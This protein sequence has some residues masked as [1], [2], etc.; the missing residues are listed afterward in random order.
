MVGVAPPTFGRNPIPP[1]RLGQ[2]QPGLVRSIYI[3]NIDKSVKYRNE[4]RGLPFFENNVLPIYL[5]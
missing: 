4:I 3:E 5:T 2:C 1:E